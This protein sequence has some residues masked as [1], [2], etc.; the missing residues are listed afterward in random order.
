MSSRPTCRQ[1]G[2]RERSKEPRYLM[3][4]ISPSFGAVILVTWPLLTGVSIWKYLGAFR[5]KKRP[6]TWIWFLAL[7]FCITAIEWWVMSIVIL[8]KVD[9]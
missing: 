2:T 3:I 8:L 4:E 1:A 7:A 6:D 5:A 9:Y